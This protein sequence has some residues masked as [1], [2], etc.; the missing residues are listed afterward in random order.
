VKRWRWA[1][2]EVRLGKAKH[3]AT[4]NVAELGG[5]GESFAETEKIVGLIGESD[6]GAGQAT[7]AALQTDGLLALFLELSG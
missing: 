6:E 4:L 2:E 3:E 7:D 5:E 1:I